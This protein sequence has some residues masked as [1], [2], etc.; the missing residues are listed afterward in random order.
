[1]RFSAGEQYPSPY[2]IYTPPACYWQ[3]GYWVNQPYV[4]AWGRYTYVPEWVA[5]QYVCY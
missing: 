2:Y 5:A 1:M 4:D 3:P